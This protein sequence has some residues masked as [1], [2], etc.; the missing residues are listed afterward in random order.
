MRRHSLDRIDKEGVLREAVK[1]VPIR[2]RIRVSKEAMATPSAPYIVMRMSKCGV[3]LIKIFKLRGREINPFLPSVLRP[4]EP[5]ACVIRIYLLLPLTPEMQ[6]S[7]GEGGG[8]LSF[9]QHLALSACTP[10]LT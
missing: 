9:S 6:L 4:Q 8:A 10:G 5:V 3:V 7:S 1:Q 2:K